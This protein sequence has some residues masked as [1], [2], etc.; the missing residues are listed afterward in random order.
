[1]T[2]VPAAPDMLIG[3][4]AGAASV[5]AMLVERTPF[6]RL[7]PG[8]RRVRTDVDGPTHFV[9]LALERQLPPGPGGEKRSRQAD[10]A[11]AADAWVQSI[12][13]AVAKLTFGLRTEA[14]R[15]GV[16]VDARLDGR[17]RDVV[18][19]R[20]GARVEGLPAEIDKAL[21]GRGI[22][23]AGPMRRCLQL[24][25]AWA[26]GEQTSALGLLGGLEGGDRSLVVHWDEEVFLAEARRGLVPRGR[27]E[28]PGTRADV[29]FRGLSVRWRAQGGGPRLLPA[30][31]GGDAA[32]IQLLRGGAEI[33][34]ARVGQRLIQGEREAERVAAEG[35]REPGSVRVVVGGAMGRALLDEQ[36][37][38]RILGGLAAG[39][40]GALGEAPALARRAGLLPD[41]AEGSCGLAE[42]LLQLSR[43]ASAPLIGAA[44]LALGGDDAQDVEQEPPSG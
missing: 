35:G 15:V 37:D 17:G 9:P 42:G 32:A 23:T 28:A 34:G 14:L 10:E 8:G 21:R 13:N 30:A 3:V 31:R 11:R 5:E 41:E 20:E 43:E 19:M 29:G 7:V 4:T 27:F 24:G 44:A 26:L 6:G 39:I 16:A 1:M 40:R 33:L 2:G 22:E 25:D 12:A 38:D 18:A 36:L